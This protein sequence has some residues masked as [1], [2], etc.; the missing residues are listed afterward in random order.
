MTQYA[1]IKYS[2]FQMKNEDENFL[3]DDKW[4]NLVLFL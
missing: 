2:A 4:Y 1:F 3:N